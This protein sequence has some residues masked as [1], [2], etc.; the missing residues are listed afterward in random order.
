[1]KIVGDNLYIM[2]SIE[3]KVDNLLIMNR[4]LFR[5]ELTIG[6]KIL[7]LL[8]FYVNAASLLTE[9]LKYYYKLILINELHS[10]SVCGNQINTITII[11]SNSE[12]V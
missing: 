2:I 5:S 12:A 8:L 7:L 6:S 3:E 4:K 10:R 1:M 9:K 11:I